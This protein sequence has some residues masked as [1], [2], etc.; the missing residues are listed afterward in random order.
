M[1]YH[2]EDLRDLR[3]ELDESVEEVS[4]EN[5]DPESSIPT[6]I[7]SLTPWNETAPEAHQIN[8]NYIIRQEIKAIHPLT[9]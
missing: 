1:R 3:K 5:L 9:E 2:V 7:S 6:G 8:M 4:K